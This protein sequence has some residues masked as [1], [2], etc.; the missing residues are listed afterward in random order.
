MLA[1]PEQEAGSGG[2]GSLF[3]TRRRP[4]YERFR[5]LD[6]QPEVPTGLPKPRAPGQCLT[7]RGL[8]RGSR[9]LDTE[10]FPSSD[11]LG[12]G[13]QMGVWEFTQGGGGMGRGGGAVLS[14]VQL[15]LLL[16]QVLPRHLEI[17]LMSRATHWLRL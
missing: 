15:G 6:L 1:E 7:S 8:G 9:E 16:P 4:L 11:A 17:A 12:C 10:A 2:G 5:L 13:A 14:A 3:S